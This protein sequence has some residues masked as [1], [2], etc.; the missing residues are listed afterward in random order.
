[1]E[2]AAAQ[3]AV[4]ELLAHRR[5]GRIT[6]LYASRDEKRNNAV[7]LKMWLERQKP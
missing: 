4:K 2:S 5:K 7:A 3:E 6:L 1:M